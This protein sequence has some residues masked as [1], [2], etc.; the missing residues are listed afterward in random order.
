[1]ITTF[2]IITYIY[3]QL[4]KQPPPGPCRGPWATVNNGFRAAAYTYAN[5]PVLAA[6]RE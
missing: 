6:L 5:V 3:C 1:M 4:A 2:H